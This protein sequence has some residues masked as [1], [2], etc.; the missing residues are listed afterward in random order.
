MSVLLDQLKADFLTARKNK[1]ESTPLL[2]TIL[3]NVDTH[4]KSKNAVINDEKI[5]SIV[6]TI[7]KGTSDTL[8]AL[9]NSNVQERDKKILQCRSELEI[10]SKY[11]PLLMSETELKSTVMSFIDSGGS[12]DIGS[13]MKFL[14]ENHTGKYDG[15]MASQIVKDLSD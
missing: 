6:K 2:S 8:S 14:R 7:A 10:L 5:I 1:S 3:G 13:V 9:E 15:K 11:I 12:N 4:S